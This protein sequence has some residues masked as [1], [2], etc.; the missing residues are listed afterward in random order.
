MHE[1]LE[2]LWERPRTITGWLTS[3]D[4]KDIGRRYLAT[5]F[6]FLIIGGVEALLIRMQLARPEQAVLTPGS[7]RPDLHACTA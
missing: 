4:H 3:V 2:Q 6:A 1:R 7:L 5:A